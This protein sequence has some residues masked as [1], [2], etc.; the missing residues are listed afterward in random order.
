VSD[1]V[2][3][4]PAGPPRGE[5]SAATVPGT[6]GSATRRRLLWRLV[7]LSITGVSLYVVA[8]SIAEVFTS[9]PALSK[10]AVGWFVLVFGCQVLSF[11]CMFFLQRLALRTS[12]WFSVVTSQL[13]GNAFSQIVPGG[14]AAG[15]ALQFRMLADAGADAT[16]AI[17]GLTAFSLL[18]T[19]SVLAL[20]LLILPALLGGVYVPSGLA[21]S[22]LLGAGAFVL[23]AGLGIVLMATDKPLQV[24]ARVAQTV[25]NRC[26]RRS[27]PWTGLSARILQ[28]RDAVRAALG[29]R[30]REAS[31][32]TAGKLGF[33][34]L[35]LLAALEARSHPNP[36]LVLVA[37]SAARVLAMIPITPGGL[38]FVEAGL[39]A[40]LTLAGVPAGDA[41]VATLI[42]RLASYWLPILAGPVAYGLFWNRY[43]RRQRSAL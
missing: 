17:S 36:A 28:E 3:N 4:V 34:Y 37:F 21:E 33:D 8:P 7:M 38:G 2:G 20:P 16:A 9:W 23:V 13:A 32:A 35:S 11:G 6:S 15:A 24:T 30:W 1:Q 12:A 18:Q 5:G 40:T 31:L 26:A 25:H 39:T 29:A 43:L 27:P 41:V 19:A 14:A 22:A 10:V 42:Y